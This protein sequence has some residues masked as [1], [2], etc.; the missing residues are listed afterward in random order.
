MISPLPTQSPAKINSSAIDRSAQA[1]CAVLNGTRG[2]WPF[3]SSTV[4]D[5][6]RRVNQ[7]RIEYGAPPVSDS[8][9]LRRVDQ[10]LKLGHWDWD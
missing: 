2:P 3:P 4:E 5:V 7:M 1:V 8:D 10:W 6:V 9:V